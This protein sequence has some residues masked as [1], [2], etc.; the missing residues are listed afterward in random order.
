MNDSTK[1]I[2]E[3]L[4]E[5]RKFRESIE[6]SHKSSKEGTKHRQKDSSSK[7]TDNLETLKRL[8]ENL[9]EI[10]NFREKMA[11]S[12][13]TRDTLEERKLRNNLTQEHKKLKEAIKQRTGGISD[14]DDDLKI[15]EEDSKKVT[16][17][18]GTLI[19]FIRNL[20]THIALKVS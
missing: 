5:S 14:S 2:R 19:L 4:E 18:A 20:S 17:K 7:P 8:R 11:D 6:N 12:R 10:H 3:N 15:V 1:K 9:A 13:K 16:K